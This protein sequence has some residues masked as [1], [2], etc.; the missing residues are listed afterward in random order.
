MISSWPGSPG[1]EI[2]SEAFGFAGYPKDSYFANQP[3]VSTLLR[4][5]GAAQRGRRL[6]E[7]THI[8]VTRP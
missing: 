1:S 3:S 5:M 4:R 2:F 7:I 6:D 8:L